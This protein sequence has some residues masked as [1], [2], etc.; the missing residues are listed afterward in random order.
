MLQHG[1]HKMRIHKGIKKTSIVV[2]LTALFSF[3][4]IHMVQAVTTAPAEPGT[5]G[6]PLV[7]QS[8]VDSKINGLKATIDDLNK[9]LEAQKKYATFTVVNL[10]AGQQLIAGASSEIIVRS[11]KVTAISGTNG[12]GLADVTSDT[13]KTYYTGNAVPVNHLILIS[14]D[15]GRGIKAANEVYILFKGTYTIK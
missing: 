6:D 15:D 14:R 5:D 11:G 7:T 1:V 3:L 9:Q 10:K 13:S 8:Y 12:D 4:L 2:I